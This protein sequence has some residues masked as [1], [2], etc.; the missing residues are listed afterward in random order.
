MPSR[1]P[2]LTRVLVR[3]LVVP[4]LFLLGVTGYLVTSAALAASTRSQ[5]G[6]SGPAARDK[7][8][9]AGYSRQF[10]GCVASVLW[11]ERETPVAIVVRWRSGKVD[12]VAMRR[13]APRVFSSVRTGQ[14]GDHRRL[15]PQLGTTKAPVGRTRALALNSRWT[16]SRKAC[17]RVSCAG[18]MREVAD[19]EP[20]KPP[21]W[22]AR[23]GHGSDIGGGT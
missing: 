13:A 15:L 11:P 4:V 18:G 6:W 12:R 23:C 5:H 21:T 3:A 14:R 20:H 9:K 7:R 1:S 2:A 22:S 10:P 8:W 17:S 16:A 19:P